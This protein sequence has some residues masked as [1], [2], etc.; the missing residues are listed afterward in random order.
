MEVDHESSDKGDRISSSPHG[1]LRITRMFELV[2][3]CKGPALSN[4]DGRARKLI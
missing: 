3:C 2:S 4:E 1:G